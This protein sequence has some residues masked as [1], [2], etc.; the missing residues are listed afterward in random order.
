MVK[1]NLI[2]YSET[3]LTMVSTCQIKCQNQVSN[4]PRDSPGHGSVL[5]A[6][7]SISS[8]VQFAPLPDGTG[9]LQVLNRAVTPPRQETEQECHSPQSDQPPSISVYAPNEK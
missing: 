9:L 7:V 2:S 4:L 5:H 3:E 6:A 8:P 1:C